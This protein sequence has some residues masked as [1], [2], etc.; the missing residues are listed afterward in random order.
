MR[1]SRF[2]FWSFLDTTQNKNKKTLKKL[3]FLN[4]ETK[5]VYSSPPP[6]SPT[7]FIKYGKNNKIKNKKKKK[8]R[9]N[10][11]IKSLIKFP[12]LQQNPTPPNHNL[13]LLVLLFCLLITN[14][15]MIGHT[16]TIIN[17]SIKKKR[18]IIRT[19]LLMTNDN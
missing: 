16:H 18:N 13:F 14:K 7:P 9:K 6:L 19:F 2:L 15:C 4:K 1:F 12:I 17:I 8:K 3:F 11:K 10:Y 5:F